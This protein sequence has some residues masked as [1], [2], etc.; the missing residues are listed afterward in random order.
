MAYIRAALSD[1][2]Y[3]IYVEAV[4]RLNDFGAVVTLV[5]NG[6]SEEGFDGEWR[7]TDIF[8]VEG[9]LI[10]RCEVFDETDLDAALARFEELNR[11]G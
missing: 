4:H 11:P 9:D 5:S 7:M 2:V 3:S 8:A 10:S 6:T 1:G